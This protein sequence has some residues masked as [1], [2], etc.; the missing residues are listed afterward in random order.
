MLTLLFF[1]LMILIF[2]KI[3]MFAIQAAWGISK[4]VCSVILL[5]FILC[6]LVIVGLIKLA[7]P[8]LV[9]IGLVS[10]FKLHD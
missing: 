8:I 7:L 3:L 4:I 1:A 6:V 9:I 2:G 5:P 10:L